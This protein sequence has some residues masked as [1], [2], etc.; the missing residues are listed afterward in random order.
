MI[1]R[2]EQKRLR[3][4][5]GEP[6]RKCISGILRSSRIRVTRPLAPM[7]VYVPNLISGHHQKSDANI[8]FTWHIVIRSDRTL[9][10][11][12]TLL[13]SACT[14][15]KTLHKRT[16]KKCQ[17][18]YQFD[19]KA[20]CGGL[21]CMHFGN[22]GLRRAFPTRSAK[23]HVIGQTPL[24]YGQ[25][26]ESKARYEVPKK[27]F[28]PHGQQSMSSNYPNVMQI[29]N[30]RLM[31]VQIRLSWT[32]MATFIISIA[33]TMPHSDGRKNKFCDQIPDLVR[34]ASP[35]D[36]QVLLSY[37]N[38]R[39]ATLGTICS[40]ITFLQVRQ[41][42]LLNSDF[43]FTNNKHLNTCSLLVDTNIHLIW[44]QLQDEPS[45]ITRTGIGVT[46]LHNERR[47]IGCGMFRAHDS[48]CDAVR[49]GRNSE[50]RL[51]GALDSRF[52][53]IR[54]RQKCISLTGP[55]RT[56]DIRGERFT[57]SLPAQARH[58]LTV[59]RTTV[60]PTRKQFN[61][62]I[63]DITPTKP[64][65]GLLLLSRISPVEFF[66][67]FCQ[68][69]QYKPQLRI[70]ALSK[71]SL[72]CRHACFKPWREIEPCRVKQKEKHRIEHFHDYQMSGRSK[73]IFF[74]N[75]RIRLY[76]HGMYVSL[77]V[78]YNCIFDEFTSRRRTNCQIVKLATFKYVHT[79]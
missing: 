6:I 19:G 8:L 18:L 77:M 59:K 39:N 42:I 72:L 49:Q 63:P 21:I 74:G 4:R 38:I 1:A 34:P 78:G 50:D 64:P 46:V 58:I 40:R 7:L 11:N 75:K 23:M 25:S 2:A 56:Y 14:M 55:D 76:F 51:W 9:S 26:V 61:D 45:T 52:T 47:P 71:Q 54:A 44:I 10:A 16:G 69:F 15:R 5:Y 48:V 68:S 31:T 66:R 28:C 36:P 3:N 37:F 79:H 30:R 62:F 27:M 67:A 17:R 32:E 33:P 22:L 57:T 60:Y 29:A 13:A 20:D 35:S 70:R 41:L 43:P 53:L 12:S 24:P 73:T 65:K